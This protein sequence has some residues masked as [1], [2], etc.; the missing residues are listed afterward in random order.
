MNMGSATLIIHELHFNS[1]NEFP[2]H[3]YLFV[4]FHL[5]SFTMISTNVKAF[6][7]LHHFP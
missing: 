5:D 1:Y 2:R 3:K 4:Y 7:K 6:G